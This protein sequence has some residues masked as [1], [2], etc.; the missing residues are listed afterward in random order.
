MWSFLC[1]CGVICF[2]AC[3]EVVE[4]LSAKRC[5]CHRTVVDVCSLLSPL[6]LKLWVILLAYCFWP[7]WYPRTGRHRL[8]SGLHHHWL[9][10]QHFVNHGFW[11][12]YWDSPAWL[13]LH[14]P[15]N[16]W[17]RQWL[18]LCIP[19]CQWD[20]FKW[21]F[22]GL[23][24]PSP[25]YFPPYVGKSICWYIFGNTDLG[26]AWLKSPARM[27]NPSGVLSVARQL[28]YITHWTTE[29]VVTC[30]RRAY[31]QLVFTSRPIKLTGM[32]KP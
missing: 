17:C 18:S 12:S 25:K 30:C 24:K 22:C 13:Q 10:K 21:P 7:F 11:S 28:N 26:S 32:K 14:H 6:S 16:W 4:F 8:F 9:W 23:C 27:R 19:E 3:K 20:G 1:R 2:K 31:C 29:R 15:C 5:H